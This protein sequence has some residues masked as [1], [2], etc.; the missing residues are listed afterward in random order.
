MEKWGRDMS[1][2]F[3][4]ALRHTAD[5]YREEFSVDAHGWAELSQL[6]HSRV[7]SDDDRLYLDVDTVKK[8]LEGRLPGCRNDKGRFELDEVRAGGPWIR[9]TGDHSIEVVV[10]PDTDL[11]PVSY[12]GDGDLLIPEYFYHGV[13]GDEKAQSIQVN[14][15]Q[16]GATSP[17]RRQRPYIF[18]A[19]LAAV[20]PCEAKAVITD[21]RLKLHPRKMRLRPASAGLRPGST[22]LF[23]IRIREWQ[24]W[25]KARV[26]RHARK[27]FYVTAGED[28]GV[29]ENK[30]APRFCQPYE[31]IAEVTTDVFDT[32]QGYQPPQPQMQTRIQ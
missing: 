2:S 7:F 30:I 32:R 3:Q 13:D 20:E 4:M 21:R 31:A 26:W 10:N 12:D 16:C 19:T 28:A 5:E 25:S 29:H 23:M 17:G 1:G 22:K 11:L 6:I 24:Q 14:G 8:M 9:A 18:L 15:I 27:G